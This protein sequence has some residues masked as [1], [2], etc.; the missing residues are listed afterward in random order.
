MKKSFRVFTP[1]ACIYSSLRR[2]QSKIQSFYLTCSVTGDLHDLFLEEITL[3]ESSE[4]KNYRLEGTAYL[5]PFVKT[6]TLWTK[7]LLYAKW[8]IHFLNTEGM[9][10]VMLLTI[11]YNYRFL[12]TFRFSSV[13]KCTQN[14]YWV[15]V[16]MTINDLAINLFNYKKYIHTFK[17]IRVVFK[18]QGVNHS[19]AWPIIRSHI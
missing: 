16:N 4:R 17:Y 15:K 5:A 7:T 12:W 14:A 8:F 13:V 11:L 3:D 6:Y 19:S 9:K 10:I 1:S 2:L 18:C